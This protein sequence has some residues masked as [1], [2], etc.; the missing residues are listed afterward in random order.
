MAWEGV[1]TNAG[2]ALFASWTEG[3]ELN[4]DGTTGATGGTGTV[5]SAALMAQTALVNQKQTLSIVS[6]KKVQDGILLQIQITAPATGY[7]LNQIGVWARLDGGTRT[8]IAVFQEASNGVPIP[9]SSEMPDF[10]WSD[11]S[12]LQMSNT[13]TLNITI[14]PSAQVSQSTLTA[15]IAAHDEDAGA[16]ADLFAASGKMKTTGDGFALDN[17]STRPTLGNKAVDISYTDDNT[18]GALGNYSYAEG[19]ESVSGFAP[20]TQT[21]SP[22]DIVVNS[23][24]DGTGPDGFR[25]YFSINVPLDECFK[26]DN[27]RIIVTTTTDVVTPELFIMRFFSDDNTL[28]ATTL[29]YV[30]SG[31]HASDN[32]LSMT[33]ISDTYGHSEGY[34]TESSGYGSHSEGENSIASG[35][36]SHA[37]G[38]NCLCLARG[39]HAEG[40]ST[41]SL[42]YGAAISIQ[43]VEGSSFLLDHLNS[44]LDMVRVGMLVYVKIAG[45]RPEYPYSI[46][47]AHIIS[48]VDL[49]ITLDIEPEWGMSG[50]FISG[51]A[52]A[53]S[54]SEGNGTRAIG[55]ASHAEGEGT[56]ASDSGSH[57]E[58]HNTVA[59]GRSSH[60]EGS[61]STAS[62]DSAHAEGNSK[63]SGYDAHSEGRGTLASGNHSHVEGDFTKAVGG[64]SHAEGEKSSA[65]SDCSHAEGKNTSAAEGTLYKITSYDTTNKTVTLD[66]VEGLVVGDILVLVKSNGAVSTDIQI[67]DISGLTVTLDSTSGYGTLYA[68]KLNSTFYSAHSEGVDSIASGAASHAQGR[69]TLANVFGS[70]A[71]GIYN[72]TMSG[73]STAYNTSN[74]AFVIGNGSSRDSRSN[75]FRVKFDGSV[76]GLSTYN[77]SGADYAEYFE[78]ADGN[79]QGEDR[80]GYFIALDGDK[81]RKCTSSDDFVLGIV[82]ARPSVVGDSYQ[83]HWKDKYLKDEWDRLLTEEVDVPAEYDEEGNET[84]SARVDVVFKINPEWENT[85]VYIPRERRMEWDSVGLMG[86][87]LVRDDGTC[88]INGYCRPNSDGIATAATNGYRVMKR[89]AD[90]VILVLFK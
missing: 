80:I 33:L 42:G 40:L 84:T 51:Y 32:I 66:N 64:A 41:V 2:K 14:D 23:A 69:G 36:S 4:I 90:N 56:E 65:V 22:G 45:I 52:G 5:P 1:I 85:Q 35:N 12:L 75:A 59:S 49:I 57:A 8:L 54:H 7:L 27:A 58:G 78:W 43:H 86:K 24:A 26:K 34:K 17:G 18:K 15:A 79:T 76:Y 16:H 9:S 61:V 87:L 30:P 6:R 83:D 60:A 53:A 3:T 72:Q 48:R 46:K 71:M 39:G 73:S 13:G 28:W 31:L 10:I 70:H 81:I 55:Y 21:F 67:T 37:E 20:L 38:E 19:V 74:D 62:G 29:N 11:Y 63:A 68:I 88:V 77:S 44:R 50:I 89:V 47:K 82:S 25:I